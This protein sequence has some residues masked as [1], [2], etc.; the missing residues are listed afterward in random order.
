MLSKGVKKKPS[1]AKYR[2]RRDEREHK[3]DECKKFMDLQKYFTS[4]RLRMRHVK[5]VK[6]QLLY[7][8]QTTLN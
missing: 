3:F 5:K 6:L 4:K 7:H 1:G 2:K 8:L